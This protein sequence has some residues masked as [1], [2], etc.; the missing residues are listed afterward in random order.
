VVKDLELRIENG[1]E[2]GKEIN[3]WRQVVVAGNG[4]K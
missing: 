4:L 3:R 2:L 1:K